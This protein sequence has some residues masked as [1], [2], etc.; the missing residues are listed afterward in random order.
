VRAS[1]RLPSRLYLKA[2]E[3]ALPLSQEPPRQDEAVAQVQALIEKKPGKR[4]P[5]KLLIFS[6]VGLLLL[7]L[8]VIS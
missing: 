2:V 8:L 6:V 5:K 4:T 1:T 7:A 3:Q